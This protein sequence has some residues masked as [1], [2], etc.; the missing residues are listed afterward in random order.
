MEMPSYFHS[1]YFKHVLD[2]RREGSVLWLVDAH[3]DSLDV[4][5]AT[6]P[7]VGK[8]NIVHLA[9]LR[10]KLKEHIKKLRQWR[11]KHLA[12]ISWRIC[13][14]RPRRSVLCYLYSSVRSCFQQSM[15][16]QPSDERLENYGEVGSCVHLFLFD[17]C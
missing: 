4:A 15:A 17:A 7:C 1:Q 14:K 11:A 5:V 12:D 13:Q 2:F 6:R 16:F 8:W 9:L 3:E 10:Q